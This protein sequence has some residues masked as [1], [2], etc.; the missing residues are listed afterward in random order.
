MLVEEIW[1]TVREGTRRTGFHLDYMRRLA[2][3]NLRLPENERSLRVRMKDRAYEIW[4]PDLINY[5]EKRIPASM[6]HLDLSSVEQIW[7][8]TT[9][10]AE[11]TGYQRGYLSMVAL[12]MSQKPENEREIR[13]KRRANGYEMWL[14]DLVI[15]TN[16]IGRGPQGKRK[17][18]S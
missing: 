9:E 16:K 2:R 4:L 15:Y 10:G 3:E 18:D 7:V 6:Q 1:I 5:V 14:P 17:I 11:A 13:I 8:N 12:R